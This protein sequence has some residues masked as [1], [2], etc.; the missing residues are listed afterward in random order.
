MQVQTVGGMFAVPTFE[1][2]GNSSYLLSTAPAAEASGILLANDPYNIFQFLTGLIIW[3]HINPLKGCASPSP[4]R[5]RL[6]E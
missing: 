2:K 4:G 6:R 5:A 3:P 1:H